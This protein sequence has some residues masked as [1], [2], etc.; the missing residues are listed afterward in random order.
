MLW[1]EKMKQD[2]RLKSGFKYLYENSKQT[3]LHDVFAELS[4]T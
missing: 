3:L 1:S 2:F 4:I